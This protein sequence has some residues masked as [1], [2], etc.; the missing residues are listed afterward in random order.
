[1]QL[2]DYLQELR[3]PQT[4]MMMDKKQSRPGTRET[5]MP[6]QDSEEYAE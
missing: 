2:S 6:I 5:Q 3:A 4:Q 1:M